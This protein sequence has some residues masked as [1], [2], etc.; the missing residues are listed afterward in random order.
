MIIKDEIHGTVSFDDL[1]AR[2]IDSPPFQRLRRIKQMSVTNLVYPG[3]NHTRFEHSIGTAHLSALIARKIGLDDD[4]V[5]KVKIYGLLHDIGHTPFSHEGEDVLERHVGNHEALG[6]RMVCRGEIADI[7]SECYRPAEIAGIGESPYGSIITSDLGADRMDYLKRD[8]LNTGVAYGIIDIDRIVHTLAM[9]DDELCI[10]KGGLEAAEYMLIAR[11]MM[12][13]TVYLHRTVR[14]ATA[15]LY[16]AMEGAISDGTCSPEALASMDDEG[17]LAAIA[18]SKKGGPYARA[19]ILRK[20]YK[21]VGSLQKEG[22]GEERARRL[23]GALSREA[24]C[25]I[26]IDYPRRFFRPVEFKVNT[27]EGL[28]PIMRLSK[29]VQSLKD[30]EEDRMR[31]LVLAEEKMRDSR[32]VRIRELVAKASR[33]S[34]RAR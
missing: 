16:R 28:V 19:L 11:F 9:K 30:A 10:G 29:I 17:A 21:E 33:S 18:C 4:E 3:A 13:S 5:R 31:V 23:E 8:A 2:V 7:L 1:E 26:L 34:R 32:A 24:G 20:L 15:M 22:W 27:D 14:I 6:K 25:D 12:F